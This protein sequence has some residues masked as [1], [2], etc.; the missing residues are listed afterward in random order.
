[1]SVF[2]ATVKLKD[3]PG[4]SNFA[5][6]M[7]KNHGPLSGEWEKIKPGAGE[8]PLLTRGLWMA[9][10][11]SDHPG[12]LVLHFFVGFTLTLRNLAMSFRR[13][14][15]NFLTSFA[16]GDV[17][18]PDTNPGRFGMFLFRPD[19]PGVSGRELM[20]VAGPGTR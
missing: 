10:D 7:F 16:R 5:R 3:Q 1:M 13:V 17:R 20:W 19:R 15:R 4:W 12:F 11:D 18:G 6:V 14:P 8:P 9:Q 2:V